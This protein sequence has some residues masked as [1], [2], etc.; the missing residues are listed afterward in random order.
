MCQVCVSWLGVAGCS[1]LTDDTMTHN[2]KTPGS[3]GGSQETVWH[4]SVYFLHF[5][6]IKYSITC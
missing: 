2:D 4:H 3:A 6:M 1:L 5:F